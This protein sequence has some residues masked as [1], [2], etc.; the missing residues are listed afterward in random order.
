M[1]INI[2]THS[3]IPIYRQITGE[4][5][6]LI[7][8]GTLTAGEQMP[9]VRELSAQLRVNPMTVSKAYSNLEMEG[10]FERRRGVGMFVN[11]QS[12]ELREENGE[13]IIKDSL[14]ST[15]SRARSFGISKA[16]LA[17]IVQNLYESY[18]KG[19]N[20]E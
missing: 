12:E 14:K 4:I 6:N 9:S 10:F 15:V 20:D 11:P 19:E 7:L 8:S 18:S 2:D 16:E 13:Q 17:R 1:I 5:K 3:G